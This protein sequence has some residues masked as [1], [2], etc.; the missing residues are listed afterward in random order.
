MAS[1]VAA[2]YYLRVVKV[3]YFDEPHKSFEPM[4][5]EQALVLIVAG[6]FNILFIVY[7]AP[8]LDA[9]STAAKSL[10]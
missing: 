5:S 9:A 2:F 6:L 7:P 8:L 1:A 4:P 3:M 10:F